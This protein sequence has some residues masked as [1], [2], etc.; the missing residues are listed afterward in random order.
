MVK[1]ESSDVSVEV[2][3]REET[4]E[5][6]NYEPSGESNSI[7]PIVFD[8]DFH[9]LNCLGMGLGQHFAKEFHQGQDT[10]HG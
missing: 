1:N 6:L 8:H 2:R 5:P 3:V 9:D 4:N 10:V 7:S